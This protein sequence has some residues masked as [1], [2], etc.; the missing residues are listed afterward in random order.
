MSRHVF[1]SAV[2]RKALQQ[3]HFDLS[4]REIARYWTLSGEDLHR[5]RRHRRDSNRFGFAVQLCLLRF[6]GWPPHRQDRVPL[7]LLHYVAEQLSI[8]TDH[9][10]EYFHR[11]PTRSDHLQEILDLY[12]FR[13]VTEPIRNQLTEWAES[14]A[15]RWTTPMG[16][17]MALIDEMRRQRM[18]LPALSTL[19]HWAWRIHQQVEGEAL[20]RLT[21]SLSVLQRSELDQMLLPAL[22]A[23]DQNLTWLRRAMGIPGAKSMLDLMDRL[24]LIRS[25]ELNPHMTEGINPL[26]LRQLASRG[27]RHTLQHLREYPPRKRFG[28]L[29]AF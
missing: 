11:Q 24:D 21:D 9:I 8:P 14:Q 19:E 4:T 18:I 6:P 27:A 15:H 25:V 5:V 26:L 22:D 17:L 7:P 23:S 29:V 1:L 10:E 20:G 16:L 28:I 12:G 13:Y 2:Q 3:A